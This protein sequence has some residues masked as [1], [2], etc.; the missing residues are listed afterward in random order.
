MARKRSHF[1]SSVSQQNN[2]KQRSNA[3]QP[4]NHKQSN[5]LHTAH[6]YKQHHH[7]HQHQH[8]HQDRQVHS[9]SDDEQQQQQIQ[10]SNYNIDDIDDEEDEKQPVAQPSA[11]Q[12]LLQ[13]FNSNSCLTLFSLFFS[14]FSLSLLFVNRLCNNLHSMFLV[15]YIYVCVM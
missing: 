3:K 9:E 4:F 6:I 11:Y 12:R 1:S 2:K 8:Q 10:T 5:T 13:L 15:I 7:P 14:L